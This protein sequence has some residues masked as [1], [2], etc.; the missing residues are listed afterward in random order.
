MKNK[1]FPVP[2][3]VSS[4]CEVC[5]CKI[6]NVDNDDVIMVCENCNISSL[7]IWK[8]NIEDEVENET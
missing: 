5:G 8:D 6:E 7:S 4:V 3:L 2:P 1:Q